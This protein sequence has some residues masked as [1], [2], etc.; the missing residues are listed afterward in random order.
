MEKTHTTGTTDAPEKRPATEMDGFRLFAN[1]I[2]TLSMDAVQKANSGHP[3]MPLGM[4]DA[5]TVLWLKYLKHNPGDDRWIDRDRFVLSAGHGSMLLYSLLHLTGYNL[6]LSEIRSFRQW[7][8]K[9]PGHP[10]FGHTPGVETTTGPLGQGISNAVGMALTERWLAERFNRPDFPIINHFTYVIASDGDLMEGISHEACSLAGHLGL[11]KLIV[12][13]DDNHI[14]ID[15]STDLAFTED[16]LAR[17]RAYHWHTQQVD[18]HNMVEVDAALRRAQEVSDRPSI[19]A[20]RTIIGY[21]SPNRANTARAHGEPLGEEEV[22]LTKQQ[23]G[24]KETAAFQIPEAIHAFREAVMQKGASL[25]HRWQELFARYQ[26][27]YPEEAAMFQQ[28]FNRDF[29]ATLELSIPSFPAETPL[30]TRAASGKVIDIVSRGIPNLVGGSADLSGS[31]NTRPGEEAHLTAGDFQGRYI[32]FGVREH[33]MGAIL[34]GM[35]LHGGVIPYG[36]TFLVF[37]DY[38]R[39]AIRLAAMMKLPVIYVF[40]HDSIGLGEDGPTHQ[41][42]E[43]L[44][45]LRV[46]PNL[47]VIRPADANETIAAW[48]AALQNRNGPTVLILTRQKLPVLNRAANGYTSAAHALKGGYVISTAPHPQALLIAS[49]S[50]VHIALEAHHQLLKSGVPTKV[51]SMPSMELFEAQPESYREAVLP[52]RIQARVAIEAGITTGWHQYVGKYG[53]I[54]GLDRFGAS[55]PYQRLYKELGITSETIINSVMRSIQRVRTISC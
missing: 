52:T 53:E 37:S 41:P 15:G 48:Q 17:F 40:T 51:V 18:G 46:I 36:G 30:A 35:A 54:V 29:P 42:V 34:N 50:E 9:T 20:C 3:G 10:E 43:Q 27:T 11:G 33:G 1:T 47:T 4:A 8:S 6:S 39:P 26:T 25:Q 49:G 28:V 16:V 38:M 14:S 21:G 19:I 32:H 2:R 13:Y 7:G 44:T 12:L 55:A 5:A 31:N 22:R 45:A 23:L 24:W